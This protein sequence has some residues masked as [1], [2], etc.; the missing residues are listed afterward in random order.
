MFNL[1]R[2]AV[3]EKQCLPPYTCPSDPGTIRCFQKGSPQPLRFFG[4]NLSEISSGKFGFPE[5]AWSLQGEVVVRDGVEMKPRETYLDDETLDLEFVM[6]MYSPHT[7]VRLYLLH[8]VMH[9]FRPTHASDL[10]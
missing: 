9:D 3:M 6:V 7:R 5:F 4:R 8:R 1:R 10:Y 2:E